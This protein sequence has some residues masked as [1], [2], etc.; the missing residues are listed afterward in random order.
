MPTCPRCALLA[1]VLAVAAFTG[2]D[3]SNPGR[4]LGL[5]DGVYSLTELT[6]DPATT[7]LPTADFADRLDLDGTVLEI[8]GGDA[9][10]QIRV[11]YSDGTPSQR[12]E[13]TVGATRGQATFEAVDASD[14]EDLADLFLPARFSLMYDTEFA[15]QLSASFTQTGV[16]LEAFDPDIYQDQRSNRGVLTVRFRRQ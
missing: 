16:D 15:S 12:I 2:C 1:I 4:D 11:R 14:R 10:A 9:E 7:S 13:L 8:F 3:S 6:F 5:I